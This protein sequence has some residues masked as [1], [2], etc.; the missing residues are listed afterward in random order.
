M[1]IK[2][3]LVGAADTGEITQEDLFAR[4]AQIAGVEPRQVLADWLD[5]AVVDF[6]LVELINRMKK[7]YPVGL[8]TNSPSGFVRSVL[9]TN[10]IEDLFD[11]VLVS[12]EEGC[13]KPAADI[14]R[15][16][17]SR[18]NCTAREAVFVDDNPRNIDA[19]KELGFSVVL[20]ESRESLTDLVNELQLDPAR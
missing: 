12:S 3:E 20:Y 10:K 15:L 9:G 17:L 2:R 18:M 6:E 14:Y 13:A 11:P 4:L 16:M 1:T 7:F 8:L 19:A 5:L